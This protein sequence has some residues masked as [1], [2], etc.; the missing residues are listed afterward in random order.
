[1]TKWERD[2]FE[3]PKGTVPIGKSGEEVEKW[4]LIKYHHMI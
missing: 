4:I 1:M 3:K 2:N